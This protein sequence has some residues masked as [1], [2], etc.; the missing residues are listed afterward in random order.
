[1][2]GRRFSSLARTSPCNNFSKSGESSWQVLTVS[3]TEKTLF[4]EGEGLHERWATP[5]NALIS[6]ASQQL[7]RFHRAEK[8][9]NSISASAC[10]LHILHLQD[11]ASCQCHSCR[12]RYLEI[13]WKVTS[14]QF[15]SIQVIFSWRVQPIV[16]LVPTWGFQSL[17]VFDSMSSKNWALRTVEHALTCFDFFGWPMHLTDFVAS[18]QVLFDSSCFPSEVRKF[19]SRP[20]GPGCS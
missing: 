18:L 1:M 8:P 6:A 5:R 19:N 10:S 7:S 11:A 16:W 9:K 17:G 2:N 14:G 20:D 4:A 15:R 12:G 13:S 3:C